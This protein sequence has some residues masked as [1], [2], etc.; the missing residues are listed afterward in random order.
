MKIAHDRLNGLVPDYYEADDIGM[1][2]ANNN[3]NV[4]FTTG[5]DV[6]PV[7]LT[8]R[9]VSGTKKLGEPDPDIAYKIIAVDPNNGNEV[10]SDYEEITKGT[11]EVIISAERTEGESLGTYKYSD[12]KVEILN[13]AAGESLTDD[14]TESGAAMSSDLE[15]ESDNLTLKIKQKNF[16]RTTIGRIIVYG[17]PVL[18][19]AGVAVFLIVYI[20]RLRKK[21]KDNSPKG[22]TDPDDNAGGAAGEG[23]PSAE[24]GEQPDGEKQAEEA[25]NASSEESEE[26]GGEFD[27]SDFDI[28]QDEN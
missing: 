10:I 8:V 22:P 9:L 4:K 25:E 18:I 16:L 23:E 2:A 20:P 1:V 3:F 6:E 19:I 15:V 27:A 24:G 7:R 21:R 28:G 13:A 5:F 26:Q 17:L 14:K 12:I 11:F